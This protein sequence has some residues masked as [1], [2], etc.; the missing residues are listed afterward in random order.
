MTHL[1]M[2][3]KIISVNLGPGSYQW[4]GEICPLQMV[5]KAELIRHR[6]QLSYTPYHI[7]LLLE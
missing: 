6:K 4:Y 5:D 1:R 7:T 3:L 2:S